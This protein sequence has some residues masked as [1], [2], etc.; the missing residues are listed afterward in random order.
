MGSLFIAALIVRVQCLFLVLLCNTLCLFLVL[1]SSC[2]ILSWLLYF[3][4][5]MKFATAIVLLLFLMVPW[6]GVHCVIVVYPAQTHL[7]FGDLAITNLNSFP[8]IK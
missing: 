1:Q 3:F 2:G 4:I 5:F 8:G 6:A 7:L